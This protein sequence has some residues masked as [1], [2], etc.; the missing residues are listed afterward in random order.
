VFFTEGWDVGPGETC[1]VPTK[2]MSADG[3]TVHLIFSGDDCF[4]VRRVDLA[5]TE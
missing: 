5:V 1:S 2:W 3:K 4:S